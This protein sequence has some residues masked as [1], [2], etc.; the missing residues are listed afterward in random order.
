MRRVQLFFRN[1]YPHVLQLRM[2]GLYLQKYIYSFTQGDIVLFED[3]DRIDKSKGLSN[4]SWLKERLGQKKK[5]DINRS[6]LCHLPQNDF[7]C[8]NLQ[9]HQQPDHL[10]FLQS[11]P[12]FYDEESR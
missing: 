10:F 1:I 6:R 11:N 12:L 7:F 2:C 3:R 5:E 9:I 4:Q 8:L